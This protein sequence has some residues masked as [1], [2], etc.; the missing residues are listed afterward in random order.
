MNIKVAL[1]LLPKKVEKV[2]KF[3]N[4]GRIDLLH[5]KKPKMFIPTLVS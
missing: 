1:N 3:E 2:I 4:I 5:R